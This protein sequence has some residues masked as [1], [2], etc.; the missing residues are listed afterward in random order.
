MQF[1][2]LSH[3]L[4]SSTCTI[5]PGYYVQI[6]ITDRFTV[7]FGYNN[8]YCDQCR[9]VSN[10]HYA[11]VTLNKKRLVWWQTMKVCSP[12]GTKNFWQNKNKFQKIQYV[13]IWV[14]FFT[15]KPS[16]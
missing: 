13:K 8:Q 12:F 15:V 2:I 9:Y 10:F 3:V 16:K 4:A 7:E 1:L 6:S 11:T 5:T 14:T